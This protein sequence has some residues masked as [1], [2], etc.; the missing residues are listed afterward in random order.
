[1]IF[2]R[3]EVYRSTEQLI[4]LLRTAKA[5]QSF[6]RSECN[7]VKKAYGDMSWN[8]CLLDMYEVKV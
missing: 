4:V 3:D 8:S 2:M 1:M 6:G 5:P 7:R